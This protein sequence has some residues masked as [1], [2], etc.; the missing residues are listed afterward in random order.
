MTIDRR[1]FLKVAGLQAGLIAAGAQSLEA[2]TTGGKRTAGAAAPAGSK[3]RGTFD[4]VV[5][6]AGSWGG[7]T[8]LNLQQKGAKVLLIDESGP[9]NARSTSGDETRGVRSSYG[10]RT[11]P[12][13]EVWARWARRAMTKWLEFDATWGKEMKIQH[14]Y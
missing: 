14:F 6:G 8:A 10:D 7:W 5:I 11:P 4:V 12:A 2:A 1:E 13:G 9:G 3:R